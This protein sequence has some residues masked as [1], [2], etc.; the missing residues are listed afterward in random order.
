MR[1]KY[2]FDYD[3]DYSLVGSRRRVEL[4]CGSRFERVGI[5]NPDLG[6]SARGRQKLTVGTPIDRQD[7]SVIS[8]EM[9]HY[10]LI[11]Q[12]PDAHRPV[13]GCA[14]DETPIGTE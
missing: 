12:A 2:H 7:M 13:L 9:S 8:P 1:R 4:F 5:K 14:C 11:A 3:Y 6:I 10:V